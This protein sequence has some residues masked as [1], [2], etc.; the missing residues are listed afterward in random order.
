LLRICAESAQ[1]GTENVKCH[2]LGL[3][4]GRMNEADDV[5]R[6]LASRQYALVSAAQAR[7]AGLSAWGIQRRIASGDLE[8]VHQPRVLGIVGTPDSWRRRVLA[9]VLAGGPGCAA[10]HRTAAAL[11]K[12]DGAKPG[13]VEITVPRNRRVSLPGVIVHRK[14][15]L[16]DVDL[17]TTPDGIPLTTPA[18]T[19][20]DLGAVWDAERLEEAID[21]ATREGHT[22]ISRLIWRVGILRRKGR[23]GISNVVA[24]LTADPDGRVASVLE[25]RFV[26]I[27][28]RH[29]LPKPVRQYEVKVGGELVARVD[30]AFVPLKVVIEVEGHGTHATRAQRRRDNRRRNRLEALG[31]HVHCF[32]Y[33]EV[34]FEPNAV[35]VA[36]A[37]AVAAA[38]EPAA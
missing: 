30:F 28:Q 36:V 7:Y 32:T 10:S 11:Y 29:G 35:A 21:G 31:Y 14:G 37:D 25:R 13:V 8:W 24:A 17:T 2:T 19:L 5:I 3:Y 15:D 33:E 4:S 6:R 26:R 16:H 34:C 1:I 23:D 20:V 38:V 22:S 27:L 9:A 12:F 18:R